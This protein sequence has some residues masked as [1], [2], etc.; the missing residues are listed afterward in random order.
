MLPPGSYVIATDLFSFTSSPTLTNMKVFFFTDE[1]TLIIRNDHTANIAAAD[2][3][4][5]AVTNPK[6]Y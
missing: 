1:S 4:V 5:S 6:G 3:V 2:I